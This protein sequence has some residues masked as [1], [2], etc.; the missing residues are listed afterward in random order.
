MQ[1]SI[2]KASIG[3]RAVLTA[4]LAA[5][6]SAT[7]PARARAQQKPVR[8]GVL[9]EHRAGWRRLDGRARSMVW[10]AEVARPVAIGWWRTGC[11][12][13]KPAQSR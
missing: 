9:T 11:R 4:G 6:A 13:H 1:A 8:I 3:R 10:P 5:G 7:L 12:R 2:G